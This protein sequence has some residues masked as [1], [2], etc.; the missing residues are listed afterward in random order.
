MGNDIAIPSE[1]LPILTACR[2]SGR[3]VQ[4]WRTSYR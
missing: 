4:G 1:S 2:R 3:S